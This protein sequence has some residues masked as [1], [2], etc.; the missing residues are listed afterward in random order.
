M[1]IC[2]SCGVYLKDVLSSTES[3]PMI[4][5]LEKE[6]PRS[7]QTYFKKLLKDLDEKRAETLLDASEELDMFAKKA[8][9]NFKGRQDYE[10]VANVAIFMKA[11]EDE[12]QLRFVLIF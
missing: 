2:D 8:L 10:K 4:N 7:L 12:L 9:D 3:H 11:L 5:Q 6:D 1:K